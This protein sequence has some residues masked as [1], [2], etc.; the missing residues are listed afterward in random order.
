MPVCREFSTTV[1]IPYLRGGCAPPRKFRA[2]GKGHCIFEWRGTTTSPLLNLCRGQYS[3][4]TDSRSSARSGARKNCSAGSWLRFPCQS[5]WF[6]L[7]LPPMHHLPPPNACSF[8]ALPIP[9]RFVVAVAPRDLQQAWPP[10]RFIRSLYR[11]IEKLSIKRYICIFFGELRSVPVTR[12]N[13]MPQ[14]PLAF[15]T[16]ENTILRTVFCLVIWT[17]VK[18]WLLQTSTL[19]HDPGSGAPPARPFGPRG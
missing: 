6:S 11:E 14:G 16:A 7:L 5:P 2:G 10:G 18:P 9:S 19:A 13:R 17:S 1:I 12:Q 4:M 15:S 3:A 8:V